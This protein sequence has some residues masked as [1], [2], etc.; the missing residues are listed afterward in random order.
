MVWPFTSRKS[1]VTDASVSGNPERALRV[2]V[3]ASLVL[4]LL[5]T[6]IAGK[7]SYDR[8][9][10]DAKILLERSLGSVYEHA[11]KVFDTFDLAARYADE[12][13]ANVTDDEIL[14]NEAEFNAR[15]RAL[16]DALPQL[17]DIW[18]VDASGKPLV[19]GTV[20]PMPHNLDLSDRDYFKVHA[21]TTGSRIY[22]S[23]VLDAR[24][25]ELRFF[26][27]TRPRPPKKDGSFRGVLVISVAP[28]YFTQF[29]ARLPQQPAAIA[30]LLRED[31]AM[32][33]WYPQPTTGTGR[34]S[35]ASPLL[36]AMQQNGSGLVTSVAPGD[37]VER[38]FAYRRLPNLG[39]YVVDGVETRAIVNE[40]LAT[41]ASHLM[42]GIPATFALFGLSLVA[43]RRTR[44]AAL[45][46]RTL[47]REVG[48]RESAEQALRQ[49]QKM[50]AVGRL[51]GGIAHDFNN[52]LTAILGNIDM[53]SRRLSDGDER[54]R[55]LLGSARQASDRAAT[56][57]QRLLSFS[58]QHPLEVRAVDINRLV[59][60]MS[61]LLRR[62]I[63][64]PI[65][66]ETVLAGGLWKAAVDPNQLENAILNLALNAR[67]AMPDG[68]RL[69]IETANTHLD[70]SYAAAQG[71]ELS[72]GQYVM[73]AVTDSGAGMTQEVKDRA[74][75]PFFTTKPMGAGSGLGLSQVYG[76]VRQS[77]GY[78]KIYSEVGV[79]ST[80][81]LYFPRVAEASG[82]QSW[83]GDQPAQ[84][85]PS[86]PKACTET[87]LLVEDD[88]EVNRF[89]TEVLRED[90]YV[91]LSASNGPSALVLLEQRAD[92]VML[93][94]DVVLP[95][96][97]NGREL[98]DEV[99]R[100]R[101]DIR[102][103]Y[104]TGYTRNA[105]IHQG[106]LDPNVELLSKPFTPDLL[107]R[108]IRQIL[109]AKL[110]AKEK[111]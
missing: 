40:W 64:E 99:S 24:A 70:E 94:T 54:V 100:R 62:T 69:T 58:R 13:T 1:G 20:F 110:V 55:R 87:I 82:L 56:L 22:V 12:L 36:A 91:V 80:I 75:E 3:V 71:E 42:F 98:A 39:V 29:Y 25:A 33:A 78:I 8:H 52:L 79:G 76:F 16:T 101:P 59:Q 72:H 46:H 85:A 30:G 65:S 108:K 31:G 97:M 88:D 14:A 6:A 74:F 93:F 9:V 23:E 43:L 111:A 18:V 53:A 66:V 49:A 32:L 57:V 2:L 11:L 34:L 15:L 83:T 104:A 102:V 60:G 92:I 73:L 61:E 95:G 26:S 5:I 77:G 103:L 41:V 51:T 28:E 107:R 17:R 27:L 4:P 37:R 96:G 86:P 19:S 21:E 48:L 44:R 38:I 45:A 89:V 106:Q 7:I 10:L 63:G 105:I 35:P 109:D 84:V 67:D 81:K 68:G 47:R 90:G 50:E